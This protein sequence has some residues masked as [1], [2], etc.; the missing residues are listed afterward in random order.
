MKASAEVLKAVADAIR[1]LE[2]L[3]P[4]A[5]A[6]KHRLLKPGAGPFSGRWSNK[7]PYPYLAPVMD[8][9]EEALVE[10]KR[11]VVNMKSTQ[12]GGTDALGVNA[13]LWLLTHYPGPMLYLTS[14]EDVA[15]E[16]VRD[17]WDF[18]AANCEPLAKKRL[19]G[20][21]NAELVLVKRFVDGKL[22]LTTSAS[23]LNFISNPYR[24]AAFDEIDNCADTMPDGSDPVLL[25]E[26]RM[27]AFAEAGA[28]LMLAWA[29]PT[30]RERGA[31]RLY[32]DRSDQRR[33]H[34]ACPHCSRWIAPRWEN[35]KTIAREGQSP[36]EAARD[37]SCYVF[38]C[39]S[40]GAEWSEGDRLRAI[41]EVRQIS[42]LPPEVARARD[43]IG[44]H[45]WAFFQPA[46]TVRRLAQE[47]VEAQ[48]D[49]AKRRVFANKTLGEPFE[50][51]VQ[52]TT[53]E[54]WSKLA[55]PAGEPGSYALGTVPAEVQF[56]TAGQ[57]SRADELHWCVWG[58]GL[59][60]TAEKRTIL[61]G[62][63]VDAGVEEGP[64]RR[65][66]SA[67]TLA[68]SDLFVLDQVLYD[69]YWPRI[70]GEEALP[71]AQGLHDSGWQPSAVYEFCRERLARGAV[72]SKGAGVDD[73]SKAPLVNWSGGLRYVVGGVDV[74][75]PQLR[76]AD[77]NTFL[78]KCELA[79]F[80]VNGFRDAAGESRR[81]LALP[82]DVPSE[83]LEHLSS[84]RLARDRRGRR[85]WVRRGPN[86][87][88]DA[89]VLA[90][91]SALNL[92]TALRIETPRAEQLLAK[93]AARAQEANRE[94]ESPG[95][96]SAAESSARRRWAPGRIRSR[97][98]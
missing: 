27:N 25:L 64:R 70:T 68:P 55:A 12:G 52:N 79:G 40:C 39:P 9:V 47:F 85:S 3:S 96:P 93:S 67:V 5:F 41:R 61:C 24:V 60:R 98:S 77:V 72:P 69:R 82:H 30:V 43:W 16:F 28:T 87:W 76:R 15:K 49:P 48:D 37:P 44:V 19:A 86:H 20:K 51:T 92:R 36:A 57:D 97:Y 34:V 33:G 18:A 94:R 38:A 78:A 22:V 13:M 58:W 29:H 63:L 4:S 89:T 91:V 32:F 74:D 35:V 31:A 53:V 8:A 65:N 59:V 83:L 14:K 71:V 54:A 88:L 7:E 10:G 81:R 2:R 26:K 45:F 17:R 75:A 95:P 50:E 73:L 46:N 23:I 62:W 66:P 21:K 90:Y 1:P 84:E 56:L 80:L 6:E 11:G 42:T